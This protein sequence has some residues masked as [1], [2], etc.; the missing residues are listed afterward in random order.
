MRFVFGADILAPR[1]IWMRADAVNCNNTVKS[2]MSVVD[3]GIS[4][5]ECSKSPYSIVRVGVVAESGLE[6][7]SGG[8][9]IRSPVSSS[10]T[11]RT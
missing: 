9:T 11:G 3:Q 1:L 4:Q 5:G 2:F 6:P 10:F 8:Y 7:E